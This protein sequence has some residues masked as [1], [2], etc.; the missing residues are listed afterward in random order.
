MDADDEDRPLQQPQ[1]QRAPSRTAPSPRRP[2]VTAAALFAAAAL[3]AVAVALAVVAHAPPGTASARPRWGRGT[4]FSRPPPPELLLAAVN[5]PYYQARLRPLALSLGPRHPIAARRPPHALFAD[6][7][8]TP[9]PLAPAAAAAAPTKDDRAARLAALVAASDGGEDAVPLDAASYDLWD[10]V[11]DERREEEEEEEEE[12]VAGLDGGSGNAAEV[13]APARRRRPRER[14]Q[15]LSC[16]DAARRLLPEPFHPSMLVRN[17]TVPTSWAAAPPSPQREE[18]QQ[19]Q[20]HAWRQP[21]HPHPSKL[22]PVLWRWDAAAADGDASHGVISRAAYDAVPHFLGGPHCP[23]CYDV[24]RYKLHRGRLY[25]RSGDCA[26]DLFNASGPPLPAGRT[27]CPPDWTRGRGVEE[28]LLVAAWL[29][30]LPDADVAVHR[31]DGA[32][33]G[34]PVLQHNIRRDHPRGGF[35]IPYPEH[36]EYGVSARQAL[37]WAACTRARYGLVASKDRRQRRRRRRR[38]GRGHLRDAGGAEGRR[39][40]GAAANAT[41]T[42]NSSSSTSASLPPPLRPPSCAQAPLI[43][44]AV[45][46][47][48]TTDPRRGAWLHQLLGTARARLHALSLVHSDVLDSRLVA[49]RQ[50]DQTPEMRADKAAVE[51]LLAIPSSFATAGGGSG[52]G[53]GGGGGGG[54]SL[55]WGEGG[56]AAAKREASAR[57]AECDDDDDDDDDDDGDDDGGEE[58]AARPLPRPPVY[59]AM[60]DFNRWSAV[61]DVD[62]NGWSARLFSLLAGAS[63]RP[64]LKQASPLAA[65]YEHLFAP[66]RHLAHFRGDL[67]DAA[68]VAARWVGLAEAA[69]EGRRRRGGGARQRGGGTCRAG[70]GEAGDDDDDDD[71]DGARPSGPEAADAMAAEAAALAALALN[72]WALVESAAAALEA[73]GERTAWRAAPPSSSEDGEWELVPFSSCCA[74]GELPAEFLAAM[75]AGGD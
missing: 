69:G 38:G 45:W 73:Y 57:L 42:T 53:G 13:A 65:G 18:Q 58:D 56:E 67:R 8:I 37:G 24:V 32:A 40:P 29:Y 35:A 39:G 51:R 66:G 44:R 7:R 62:G 30:A 14:R 50:L 74:Y 71:D 43:P 49:V 22:S 52:S 23:L 72:R 36:W 21:P 41:T 61:L 31:G 2:V 68:D 11:T 47:G 4:L 26:R 27:R 15:R 59:A 55:P 75:R 28:V 70:G 33:A 9:P 48:T 10:V 64:V 25:R 60:E 34:S 1:Q 3:L 17:R 54:E 12:E 16:R 6:V 20:Q 19:Q 63:A 5:Q 46:R